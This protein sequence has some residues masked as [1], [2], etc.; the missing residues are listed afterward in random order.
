MLA[1]HIAQQLKERGF[2]VL[3]END[4]ERCWPTSKIARP[5]RERE[6]LG[7]AESQPR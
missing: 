1:E 6:I 7:F 2:C 5:E 3:F 4:L